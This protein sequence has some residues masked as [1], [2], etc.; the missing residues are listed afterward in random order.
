MSKSESY[1]EED[2]SILSDY[3][4]DDEEFQKLIPEIDASVKEIVSIAPTTSDIINYP[5][6]EKNKIKRKVSRRSQ[7]RRHVVCWICERVMRSDN[8]NRHLRKKSHSILKEVDSNHEA[9][10]EKLSKEIDRQH[11]NIMS[12]IPEPYLAIK[13]HYSMDTYQRL[14]RENI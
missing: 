11:N 2:T 6:T 7:I 5:S 14:C 8:L 10:I 4:S 12:T 9:C 1:L 3:F 13:K